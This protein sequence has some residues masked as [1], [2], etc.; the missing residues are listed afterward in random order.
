[1]GE[2]RG[3]TNNT[4]R[5]PDYTR[6]DVFLRY[7][8]GLA[9]SSLEGLTASINGRNIADKRF[10]ST[11]GSAVGCYYGQGRSITARLAFRW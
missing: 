6:F 10:V 11:C 7:D 1:M 4:L 9:N 3:D 5:I 8:F 2:L